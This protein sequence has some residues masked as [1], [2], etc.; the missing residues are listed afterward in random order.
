MEGQSEGVTHSG[1]AALR[2][3]SLLWASDA[4]CASLVMKLESDEPM[5]LAGDGEGICVSVRH[6]VDQHIDRE[7]VPMW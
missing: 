7:R 2:F 3:V 6:G 1:N 5:E 4:A